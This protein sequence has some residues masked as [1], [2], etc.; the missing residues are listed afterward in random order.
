M[1]SERGPKNLSESEDE[2][3]SSVRDISHKRFCHSVRMGGAKI[4]TNNLDFTKSVDPVGVHPR[5]LLAADSVLGGSLKTIPIYGNQG[6]SA[7][8]SFS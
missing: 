5:Y 7:C 1:I 2:R 6:S 3:L 4:G 8:K